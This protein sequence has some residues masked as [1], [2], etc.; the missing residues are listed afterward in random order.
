MT[1]PLRAAP[2]R[3]HVVR[4]SGVPTWDGIEI[5]VQPIVDVVTGSA[6]A[7]EALARF[8]GLP[9]VSPTDVFANAQRSGLAV[10][11]ETACLRAALAVRD[12]LPRGVRLSVNVSPDVLTH[13]LLRQCW[14]TDLNG[15]IVEVSEHRATSPT[16]LS[17]ELAR[18]RRRGAAIAIDDVS[19]G[20][21]GL[22]RLATL[23]PDFV[24]VDRQ[25]I[26]GVRDSI[27]QTAVLEALVGLSHRLGAAVIAEGVERIADL[28][29]L[30]E[31]DVDCAQGF[32][33]GRPTAE[34]TAIDGLVVEP[35]GAA[36][37]SSDA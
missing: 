13:P 10:E 7:V 22:L 34:L 26:V 18:L 29:A 28:T 4:A 21:A 15:V 35:A 9:A 3:L 23:R 19:T 2:R 27:A 37:S 17:D 25:V 1:H 11:L 36:A 8:P 14:P 32:A 16:Q 20:Y 6:V 33:V 24:K 5:H 31:F 30:A 12:R